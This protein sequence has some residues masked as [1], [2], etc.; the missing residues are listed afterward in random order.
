MN[1]FCGSCDYYRKGRRMFEGINLLEKLQFNFLSSR[2][3]NRVA[4][5]K[6]R[7]KIFGKSIIST[8][9]TDLY[10]ENTSIAI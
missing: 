9:V 6:Q 10:F 2:V 8:I 1:K 5:L 4:V 7:R 3:F